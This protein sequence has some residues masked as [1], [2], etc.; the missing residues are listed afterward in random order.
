[1]SGPA[2]IHVLLDDLFF[3]ARIE[4]TAG[5]TGAAVAFSRTPEELE[6]RLGEGGGPATVIVD[7]GGP[8]DPVATIRALKAREPAPTVVAYGSHVDRERLAGARE[9]GADRIL[10]RSAFT[11][12]L[13]EILG[14]RI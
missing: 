13:P 11:E 5:S 3:R 12:R 4:A 7:L 10:A 2:R 14:G 9:A 1:M 8:G 6:E